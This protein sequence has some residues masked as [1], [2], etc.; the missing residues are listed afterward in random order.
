MGEGVLG[1]N[2]TPP[3]FVIDG[4]DVGVFKSIEDAVLQ[5]EPVD[6]NRGEYSAYDGEG[7]SLRLAVDGSKVTAHLA[8]AKA[9]HADELSV[10][11]REFLK[12]MGEK[13][14]DDPGCDLPCLV[15]AS[16]T[17]MYSPPRLWPFRKR[18]GRA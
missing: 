5:L 13:T 11:L 12:A 16:R 17:F 1:I 9:S 18:S 15:E 10:A 4:L 8:E 3:V 7:R 14:A 6:V 2:P